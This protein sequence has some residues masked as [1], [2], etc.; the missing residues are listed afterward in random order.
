MRSM[1][2]TLGPR[3]RAF[4]DEAFPV[5]VGTRRANGSVAMVPVWFD[6]DGDQIRING[7]PNR[8]WVKR[9][10]RDGNVSLM[11]MDPKNMWRHALVQAR[12]VEVT[13]EGADEHIELLSQRYVGGPYQNPKI[14][15]L[16]VRLAPV[17]VSGYENGK[18]WDVTES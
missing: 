5:I 16:L 13:A 4:L 10:E 8:R 15:R 11:F 9:L 2:I 18:P 6:R 12:P 17:K 3:L 1:A 7:G 14:D